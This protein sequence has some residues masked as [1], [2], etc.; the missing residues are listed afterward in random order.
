MPA[1]AELVHD[2]SIVTLAV[3]CAVALWRRRLPRPSWLAA[4]AFGAGAL[5]N[6][7]TRTGA[8]LCQPDSPVQG[9]AGWHV[10]TAVALAAWLGSARAPR[11]PV[12]LAASRPS[13][14]D[15]A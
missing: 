12:L 3:A 13:L 8:P 7:L 6:V 2:G 14:T 4:A 5:A 1:G 11:D 9:H 10:L 15:A